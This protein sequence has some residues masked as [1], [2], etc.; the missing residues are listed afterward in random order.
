[1]VRATPMRHSVSDL[2]DLI[3]DRRTIQPKDFTDRV[4][5]RDVVERVLGNGTWAP[6]HGMTQPWRFKVF[7]GDARQRL[8]TFMG[9]EYTRLT[10]PEKFLPRKFENVTQRPLQSSVVVALGMARDPK[11]K[12]SDLE[13]QLAMACAVQNMHLTCAAYGLGAFWGT[14]A[15]ATGEGM[16]RFLGLAEGDR[17]MGLFFMGYPAVEW[18]KGYRKPLPDVMEWFDR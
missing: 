9:E 12:I 11:G 17:C 8:S 7:A 1:M 5:Q 14:G 10:T 18:P 2:S 13:E 4:V 3:R 16:R 6:T 15:A